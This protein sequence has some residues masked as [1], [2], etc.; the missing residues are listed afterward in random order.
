MEVWEEAVLESCNEAH[1]E[2]DVVRVEVTVAD[3]AGMHVG[4][5]GRDA[6][7]DGQDRQPPRPQAAAKDAF[8]ERLLKAAPVAVLLHALHALR[9]R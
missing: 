3:S 1:P 6:M 8:R 4:H 9:R 5:A 7:Q 2:E